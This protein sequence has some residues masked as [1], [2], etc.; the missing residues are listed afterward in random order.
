[1]LIIEIP[2]LIRKKKMLVVIMSRDTGKANIIV[3]IG[4]SK[5]RNIVTYSIRFKVVS[6]NGNV[7]NQPIDFP[8]ITT[9]VSIIVISRKL[10]NWSKKKIPYKILIEKIRNSNS[11]PPEVII[12]M[13]SKYANNGM[14]GSTPKIRA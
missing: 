14:M 5:V 1:M 3:N 4:M 7:L 9:V 8:D 12:F 11:Y 13:Y 6:D 10:K 2:R